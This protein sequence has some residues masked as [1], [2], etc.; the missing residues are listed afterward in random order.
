MLNDMAQLSQPTENSDPMIPPVLPQDSVY[1]SCY[2]EENVYLL[3]KRFSSDQ[4]VTAF[5]D[6]YVVFISNRNKTVSARGFET[7]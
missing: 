1:T 6:P 3:A 5:W 7:S 2:C 4:D